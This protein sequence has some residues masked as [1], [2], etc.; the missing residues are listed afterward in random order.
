MTE[1]RMLAVI[2]IDGVL[3]D[4]R[5]RLH[6]VTESPKDWVAFFAA[7]PEDPVLEKGL[8]TVRKLAEVYDVVYLSGRPENCRRDTVDW[9]AK[10]GV[11]AGE[12]LLR[13]HGDY[14]PARVMKIET[15]DLLSE[16]ASVAVLVDDDPMVCTA[17]REAGYDVLVADWMPEQPTLFDAQEIEGRT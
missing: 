11:P 12:L 10:H 8:E 7:A 1:P 5:H 6:H 3:A 14:R 2:D 16:H 15:L 4:V 17:A 9:F 13:R